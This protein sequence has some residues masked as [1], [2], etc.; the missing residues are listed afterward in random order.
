MFAARKDDIP[1]M[2]D[3]L[4]PFVLNWAHEITPELDV[5]WTLC[6]GDWE[7]ELRLREQ[8]N[9]MIKA[10]LQLGRPVI[11]RSSGWSLYPRVWANDLC[12]YDPVTTADEVHEDVIVFARSSLATVSMHIS[13][14]ASGST[15]ANGSSQCPSCRGGQTV[16]AP[17]ST[18]TVD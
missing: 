8:R 16:G 4:P 11:Y 7:K 5:D 12:T 6:P 9:T 15:T 14:R 1:P 17:S 10:Q 13:W 18:Y 2:P 3:R